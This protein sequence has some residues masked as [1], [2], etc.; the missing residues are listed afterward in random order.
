MGPHAARRPAASGI[1]DPY[2]AALGTGRGPLFLHCADGRL[3]PL[4]VE[5]WCSVPDAADRSVLRRCKG[6]VLD[7][8]CGPGRMAAGL[9]RRGHR[10]LGIDIHPG[11]VRHTRAAGGRALRRSVFGRLPGEG[12]WHTALLLD[13]SIGIGGDPAALLVRLAEVVAPHGLLLA[14]A[15]GEDDDE[16]MAVRMCDGHGRCGAPFPWARLGLRALAA[17]AAE[18]P[19]SLEETWQQGSRAFAALRREG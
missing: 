1:A 17:V 4:D 15:T 12:G 8:G 13:G 5:R 3:L 16:R 10:A 19:W 2:A 7:V 9:L 18:T 14:E 11:A 6:A